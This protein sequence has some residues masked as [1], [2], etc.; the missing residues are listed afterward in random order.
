MIKKDRFL[1]YEYDYCHQTPLHWAAKRDKSE[2]IKLL[3]QAGARINQKDMGGRTPLFLA[4][5]YGNLRAVKALLAGKANPNL[6]TFSGQTP[7]LVTEDHK[8]K[9][10]LSKAILLHIC[11]PLIN[12]KRRQA[13]WELEG[14]SFFESPDHIQVSDF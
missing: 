6:R 11:M 7:I 2:V 8:C 1:V 14:L 13:V 9:G 5:K 10:F 12:V 4:C 3:I